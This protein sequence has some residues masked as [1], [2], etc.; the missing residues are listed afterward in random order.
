[1]HGLTRSNAWKAYV[2]PGLSGEEFG[3]R[4]AFVCF[5]REHPEPLW[6]AEP[7]RYP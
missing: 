7:R 5:C 3:L 4:H 6:G 1:M 2:S